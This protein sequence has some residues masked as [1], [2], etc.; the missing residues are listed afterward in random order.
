MIKALWDQLQDATSER[1][2]DG[3]RTLALLWESAY[4]AGHAAAFAGAVS[5]ATLKGIYEKKTFLPSLHL[6]NLKPQD[7]PVPQ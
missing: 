3:A 2:A 5:Q 6:A 1:I 7:Y 4:A